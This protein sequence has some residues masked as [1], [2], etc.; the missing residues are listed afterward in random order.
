MTT[1]S[2]LTKPSTALV[3]LVESVGILLDIPVSY[4]KSKYKAPTPSNYDDTMDRLLKDFPELISK[5]GSLHSSDVTN[6]VASKLFS[7]TIEA[8]FDYEEAVSTGGLE[9]RDMF[10][11]I[12]LVMNMLQEEKHRIPI[13]KMNLLVLVDG[14]RPSYVTLDTA[15]HLHKHGVC[16]VAAVLSRESRYT[17]DVLRHNHLPSDLARRCVEQYK[18]AE[19]TFHVDV[20]LS[21]T[22]Y[23]LDLQENIKR[24]MDESNAKIIVLGI[25]KNFSGT[26]TLSPIANWAAW[27]EG[28]LTVLVKS[29]S[30]LRP[31]PSSA[32]SRTVQ[33][34]LKSIDDLD[35]LFGVSLTVMKPGDHLVFCCVVDSSAPKGDSQQTRF[36]M[37]S[38]Q[39]W[40]AGS[41]PPQYPPNRVNWNEEI[42]L[43]LRNRIDELTDRSHIS[44]KPILRELDDLRTVAQELCAVAYEER[45][46]MMLLRRGQ[47]REVSRE[48]LNS[49][50]C[51]VILCD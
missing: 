17:A 30:R 3:K 23:P 15:A 27:Q 5:L 34:C 29:S 13:K 18:M 2:Q 36:S 28:F 20:L 9:A 46:D 50:A 39:R 21:Q 24:K 7:K 37:G 22:Q 33:C 42:I 14:S 25:D 6:H 12:T 38:R 8:G 47:N 44:G 19:D 43:K 32:M 16:H 1:I 35:Y 49:A 10:N 26:D 45:V 40:V 31:F 51:S 11:S 4:S 41:S 48:V